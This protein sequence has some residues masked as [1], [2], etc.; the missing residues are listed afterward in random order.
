V[1]SSLPQTPSS[2]SNRVS[3]I[4]AITGVRIVAAV[5]VILF[6]LR[7]NIASEFPWV[8]DVI[9]PIIFHGDYGV[10]LWSTP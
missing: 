8:Y 10:D 2:S 1:T 7:G 5:W 4:H 6:H 9:G 3:Q